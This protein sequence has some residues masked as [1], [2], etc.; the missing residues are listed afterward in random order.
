MVKYLAICYP[1]KG[2]I[3]T[4]IARKMV[5]FIWSFSFLI[6]LPWA[7]HF[8]LTPLAPDLPEVELCVEMWPHSS[9]ELLYFILANLV[10][11]YLLPLCLIT[12]CYVGIWIKVWRRHIPGETDGNARVSS[13]IQRSKLKVVKMMLIVVIIFVMS[14]LPLYI[15]FTRIKVGG[16][17]EPNSL[18]ENVLII[19]APIAQWL[20]SS[21]SCI[22][23]V[24]YAFLNKK[25]RKGF[26][27][28]VKSK[29]CCGTLRYDSA[30]SVIL[31]TR[32]VTL[33]STNRLNESLLTSTV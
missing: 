24:L 30:S 9:S 7:V 19:A 22:N 23:P 15:I 29:K 1:M 8:S 18:E 4:R 2:Q 31:T 3:T 14:W 20:G 12:A 32:A 26:K 10:L 28:I 11:C 6:S 16:D 21:N 13:V 33:R 17:I 5:L 25:F 27:A